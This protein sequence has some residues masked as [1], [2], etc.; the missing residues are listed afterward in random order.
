MQKKSRKHYIQI[1]TLGIHQEGEIDGKT[2]QLM[3]PESR[4]CRHRSD[5]FRYVQVF[6]ILLTIILSHHPHHPHH[7]RLFTSNF[8]VVYD[9]K[10]SRLSPASFGGFSARPPA[11]LVY[12][13]NS[14]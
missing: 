4:R 14:L 8:N 9:D 11:S 6:S 3:D 13:V 7:I 1:L 2:N 10:F 5:I 12:D